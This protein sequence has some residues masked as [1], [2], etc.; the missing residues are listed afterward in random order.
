[1]RLAVAEKPR[2]MRLE[3]NGTP[4]AETPRIERIMWVNGSHSVVFEVQ[5]RPGANRLRLTTADPLDTLPGGRQVSA[6]LVGDIEVV[7]RRD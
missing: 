2:A 4:A 3:A 7:E 6:L 5:L 1:M